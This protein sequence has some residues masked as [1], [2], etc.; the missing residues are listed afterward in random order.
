[1]SEALGDSSISKGATVLMVI[2][3]VRVLRVFRISKQNQT[4]VDFITA[5]KKIGS[6]LTVFIVLLFV[7]ILIVATAITLAEEGGPGEELGWFPNIVDSMYWTI[8]TVTSV[9]YGDFYPTTWRGKVVGGMT[10]LFGGLLMNVPIAFILLSFNNVYCLRRERE[11]KAG[12]LAGALLTWRN[13]NRVRADRKDRRDSVL[14][15]ESGAR[16]VTMSLPRIQQNT[17]PGTTAH[18]K[19]KVRLMVHEQRIAKKND[20]MFQG[21]LVKLILN[22]FRNAQNLQWGNRYYNARDHFLVSKYFVKWQKIVMLTQGRIMAKPLCN[23]NDRVPSQSMP[24]FHTTKPPSKMR[25]ASSLTSLNSSLVSEVSEVSEV[26]GP[27][28]EPGSIDDLLVSVGMPHLSK[29]PT[30]SPDLPLPTH[31]DQHRHR[32]EGPEDSRHGRKR[33][34]GQ[35]RRSKGPKQEPRGDG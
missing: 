28:F 24:A 3:V 15:T 22:P 5:M 8:I 12:Q 17:T 33:R 31:A 10:A 25:H 21:L 7:V 2:R 29:E 11:K 27:E 1:V 19:D 32:S 35:P 13:R 26:S 6:D 34:K 23:W 14:V 30:G 9:G 4:L 16:R 18:Y 20:T